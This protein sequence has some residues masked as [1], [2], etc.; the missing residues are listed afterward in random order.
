MPVFHVSIIKIVIYLQLVVYVFEMVK[1][2]VAFL[3]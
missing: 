3:A 2:V 1:C